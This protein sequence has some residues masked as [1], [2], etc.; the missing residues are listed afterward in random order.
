MAVGPLQWSRLLAAASGAAVGLW[1]AYSR[2]SQGCQ[3]WILGFLWG[4]WI[5]PFEEPAGRLR[6][7]CHSCLQC[8]EGFLSPGLTPSRYYLPLGLQPHPQPRAPVSC[9]G[10]VYACFSA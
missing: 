7:S 1:Y 4:D 3:E 10:F 8:V 6:C 9:C 5:L 2:L